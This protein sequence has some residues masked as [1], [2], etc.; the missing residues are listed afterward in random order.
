MID[1]GIRDGDYVV[2]EERGSAENG[3]TVIALLPG[4]EVTL[5][6]Y[7]R[8][9]KIIRLQPAN[10][11]VTPLMVPESDLSIQGVVIGVVRKYRRRIGAG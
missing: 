9:G 10:E 2:I 5:K 8:E 3:E 7:F 6:R 4:G 11:N 1:E